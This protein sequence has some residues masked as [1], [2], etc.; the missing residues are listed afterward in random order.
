MEITREDVTELSE[1]QR[2]QALRAIGDPRGDLPEEAGGDGGEG[3]P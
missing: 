1:E 2:R 3:A